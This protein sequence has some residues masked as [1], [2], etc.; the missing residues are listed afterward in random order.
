MLAGYASQL[1]LKNWMPLYFDKYNALL[2]QQTQGLSALQL[3]KAEAVA[4]P[5]VVKLL[6][7]RLGYH[8]SRVA[9][10][11][12]ATLPTWPLSQV[13]LCQGL[14]PSS[15]CQRGILGPCSPW[16]IHGAAGN[17]T[18]RQPSRPYH[19]SFIR[20]KLAYCRLADGF[21]QLPPVSPSAGGMSGEFLDTGTDLAWPMQQYAVT[22]PLLLPADLYEVRASI[23]WKL[24]TAP[25]ALCRNAQQPDLCTQSAWKF[26]RILI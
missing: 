20:G 1:V 21:Q 5:I 24:P 15:S 11:A 4:N 12:T 14:S 26:H 9:D 17:S 23:V 7:S 2:T 3:Q 19:M 16:S 13:D 6:S 22:E 8:A 10:R 18:S 25:A